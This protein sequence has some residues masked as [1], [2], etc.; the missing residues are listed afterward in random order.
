LDAPYTP[1]LCFIYG[2]HHI[3]QYLKSINRSTKPGHQCAANHDNAPAL[4]GDNSYTL[5]KKT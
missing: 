3:P 2:L 5:R 1:T 4:S